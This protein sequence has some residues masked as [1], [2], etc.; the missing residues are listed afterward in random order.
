[1][2]TP[3][4]AQNY[5][6]LYDSMVIDPDAMNDVIAITSKIQANQERYLTISNH[7]GNM[8]Y[9]FVGIIHCM[10]CEFSFNRH[11]ANGDPL[12]A[13]TVHVPAGLPHGLIPP[14]IFEDAAIA[15]LEYFGF[16]EVTNWDIPD[17]LYELEKWNGF[18]YQNHGINSPYLWCGSS[19]YSI[20]K[21]DSDGHFNPTEVSKQTGCALIIK[22]ISG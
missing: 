13:P 22:N 10:E 21:F 12:I 5:Q 7:F 9:Y 20:G 4:M 6:Q 8:P 2:L 1:M 18:G 14:Y 16:D 3:S 11:I 17:M 19:N 15:E